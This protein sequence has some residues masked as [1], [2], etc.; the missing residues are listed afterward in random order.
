M[1]SYSSE[2]T[3][4]KIYFE[5]CDEFEKVREICLQENN[6]L[7]NNYTK[8]NLIIEQHSG[9][10]V[11]YDSE[12]HKPV[13][14]GGVYNNNKF[15]SNVAR[16]GNRSYLFPEYRRSRHNMSE[17]YDI[18]HNRIIMPLIE[19]NNYDVYIITMQNRQ[20]KNNGWWKLLKK[21]L[22]TASNGMWSEPEGYIQSCPHMVQKCWQ[23]FVYYE[24]RPGA[25]KEWNPKIMLDPEWLQM[26]EGK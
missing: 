12:T 5:S 22:R 8:E 15:P 4:H 13:L 9:F 23:N 25:F 17:T 1:K 11:I 16:M 7:R 21:M 18:F 2:T 6:W 24:A 20:R 19:I 3:Y 26:P 10:T 14:M